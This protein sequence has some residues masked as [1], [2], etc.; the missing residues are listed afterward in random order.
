M[1]KCMLCLAPAENRCARCK[2]ACYC[3]RECQHAHWAFHKPDC[4]KDAMV[5]VGFP[6]K[7]GVEAML[8]TRDEM[9]SA[10]LPMHPLVHRLVEESKQRHGNDPHVAEAAITTGAVDKINFHAWAE[11]PD[12]SVVDPVFAEEMRMFAG[13]VHKDTGV[14]IPQ[15]RIRRGYVTTKDEVWLADADVKRYTGDLL[16]VLS[17]DPMRLSMQCKAPT[18]GQCIVNACAAAVKCG[19]RPRFGSLFFDVVAD[20]SEKLLAGFGGAFLFGS[21]TEDALRPSPE[22]EAQYHSV[23]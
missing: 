23:L 1:N 18:W 10:A 20:P 9:V 14:S 8:L 11:R 5:Y 22:I 2:N 19:G 16:Y 6:S 17:S 21:Q 13:A 3:S 15:R 7:P 4:R 12:G